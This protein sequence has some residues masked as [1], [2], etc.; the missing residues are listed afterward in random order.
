MQT[1]EDAS[2]AWF[3][4]LLLIAAIALWILSF[5]PISRG[6]GIEGVLLL[7]GAVALGIVFV[8]VWEGGIPDFKV[9]LITLLLIV[10]A[11]IV[12]YAVP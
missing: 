2:A 4:L 3:A 11:V 9:S 5:G 10:A 12:R 7:G 1:R 6:L 8:V